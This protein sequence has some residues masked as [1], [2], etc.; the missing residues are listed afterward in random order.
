MRIV[1]TGARMVL[2]IIRQN[3]LPDRNY[4]LSAYSFSVTAEDSILLINMETGTILSLSDAEWNLIGAVK[5]RPVNGAVLL[6]AGLA[7][8][9]KYGFLVESDTDDYGRYKQLVLAKL[10]YITSDKKAGF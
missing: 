7:D 1:R 4:R 8:C 3:V 9:V 10:A 6:E 2:D 5:E